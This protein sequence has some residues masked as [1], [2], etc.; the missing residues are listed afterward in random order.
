MF[1]RICIN[2]SDEVLLKADHFSFIKLFYCEVIIMDYY[3]QGEI[4]GTWPIKLCIM[5]S[6]WNCEHLQAQQ[7][8]CSNCISG[9]VT[10]LKLTFKFHLQSAVHS[11]KQHHLC[12]AMKCFVIVIRQ[13]FGCLLHCSPVVFTGDVQCH[14]ETGWERTAALSEILWDEVL[15]IQPSCRSYYVKVVIPFSLN[16]FGPVRS[17]FL[18]VTFFTRLSKLPLLREP[19]LLPLQINGWKKWSYI[20]YNECH[21]LRL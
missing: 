18:R 16:D 11:I 20:K 7:L 2:Q 5:G 4:Q 13:L 9:M 14:H 17:S 1:V 19:Q 21:L 15:C 8:D 6:G 3:L 10:C 12:K